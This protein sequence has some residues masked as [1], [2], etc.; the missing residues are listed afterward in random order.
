MIPIQDIDAMRRA[1]YDRSVI[2]EAE[3]ENS[4]WVSLLSSPIG[5]YF[6][7]GAPEEIQ[8]VSGVRL[9]PVTVIAERVR[10]LAPDK[11]LFEEGFIPI[12]SSIGGN[13][14]A[15]D[16]ASEEFVWADRT[17]VPGYHCLRMPKTYQKLTYSS[18]NL[19]KVLVA[20]SNDLPEKF[21]D[22]MRRGDYQE[23]FDAL[24]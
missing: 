2:E 9:L 20:I 24:D 1:G 16:P 5:S 11:I 4:R 23:T 13:C 15:Y 21:I 3:A 6:R 19:R 17:C 22:D 8:Y 18:D 14:L 7:T 12:A 10:D